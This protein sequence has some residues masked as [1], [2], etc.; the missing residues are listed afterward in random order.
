M[1]AAPNGEW[2]LVGGADHPTVLQPLGGGR[3]LVCTDKRCDV[4]DH[5]T[6]VWTPTDAVVLPLNTL[7]HLRRRDGDVVAIDGDRK[8]A[9]AIWSPTTGHWTP[10]APLPE[11]LND[12]RASELADGRILATGF[13]FTIKRP[14]AYVADELLR[15]WSVFVDAPEGLTNPYLVP[16]LSGALLFTGDQVS[17]H[18]TG[19]DGWRQVSSTTL[20]HGRFPEFKA[21]RDELLLVAL[22]SGTGEALVIGRN[23]HV[24]PTAALPAGHIGF[25]IP[26]IAAADG[27]TM[28]LF[29]ASSNSFYLWRR[30]DEAPLALPPNMI[31]PEYK[32]VA[33][34]DE[35]LLGVGQSGTVLELALD[36]K[37]PPGQPCDGLFRYLS[38]VPEPTSSVPVLGLV[39]SGCREQAHRGDAPALIA[40]VRS[41]T[42]QPERVDMGRA[43][44]CALQDDGAM[45]MLP[46]WFADEKQRQARTVCYQS[47]ATW[48]AAESVWKPAL[49]HAVDK[50]GDRWWVDDAVIKLAET[51]PTRAVR[52][53]LV[54]VLRVAASGHAVGFDALCN[55]VCEPSPTMSETR[56][57][58]CA[59]MASQH[60]AD[61]RRQEASEAAR[62]RGP[63]SR[64]AIAIG[65]SAVVAGAIAATYATRDGQTSRSIATGAG[66]VGGA[67][68]GFATVGLSALGGNWV[69]KGGNELPPA[70]LTGMVVGG[71]L[72]GIAAYAL[73]TSPSSRAPVTAAGL[74]LPYLFTVAIS[75]D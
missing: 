15:T 54:P 11:K 46:R 71:V 45:S 70:L 47:L 59:E 44:E 53:R 10:A 48:P 6:G 31:D 63:A 74:V 72:G 36:G 27:S 26:P 75:F 1:V 18:T 22:D 55:Q 69:S 17:R 8:I 29:S 40:L 32:L 68:M 39:S 66:A 2:F 38:R 60:E 23:D 35:H 16:T 20:P 73:T 9:S 30:P 52:E 33:L 41:W 57:Q 7:A 21:W 51:V 42:G 5:A 67:T 61:W 25:S 19:T 12:L 64:V 58:T 50:S 62:G 37:P 4:W 13:S 3:A 24:R 34:D 65:T 56:R 49:A 14:R 28:L 43:F